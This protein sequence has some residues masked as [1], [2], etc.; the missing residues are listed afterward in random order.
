MNGKHKKMF[1]YTLGMYNNVLQQTLNP[2]GEHWW[3]E[4]IDG[5]LL[6]ALPLKNFGHHKTLVQDH[7][8][9]YVLSVLEDFEISTS[10][11]LSVPVQPEDWGDNII[12]KAISSPDYGGLT[13]EAIDEGVTFLENC[14]AVLAEKGGSDNKVYVH[15]KSGHGRSA[16]VVV[17]YLMHKYKT[18]TQKA[19]DYVKSK[20]SAINLN[21][22]QLRSLADYYD[23]HC[24]ALHSPKKIE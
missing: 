8:V 7:K 15:C 9:K 23:K 24:K 3:N 16:T 6:G 10:T 22:T 2:Y 17:A 13:V 20:R 21:E 18:E 11:Y 12:I 4:V 5:I 1:W 14:V 19:L